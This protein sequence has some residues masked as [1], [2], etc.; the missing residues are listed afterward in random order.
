MAWLALLVTAQLVV[1]DLAVLAALRA[2]FS[3]RAAWAVTPTAGPS[4]DWARG[5][6]AAQVREIA[7]SRLWA[8]IHW[9]SD[10]EAGLKQGFEIAAPPPGG[11]DARRSHRVLHEDEHADREHLEAFEVL[12]RSDNAA[13]GGFGG[14][15][16]CSYAS[17]TQL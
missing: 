5:L 9:R 4:G 13:F 16:F 7:N 6:A 2:G 12:R 1:S 10:H 11:R 15:L 8:G 14:F 3:P 17:Q